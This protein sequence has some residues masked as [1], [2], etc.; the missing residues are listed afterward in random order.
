MTRG[1]IL[2]VEDNADDL[3]LMKRALAKAGIVNPIVTA[4]DGVEALEWLHGTGAHDGRDARDTPVLVLLDLKLPRV[5][6]LEALARLRADERTALVPVVMLTSSREERDLVAS[7]R[8][9]VNGFVRKP[10][11]FEE[12]AE[13]VRTIGLFWLLVNEPPPR[14]GG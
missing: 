2:I 14:S 10:I 4:G 1:R 8:G 12:F 5:D 9:G 7:Y 3:L 6:G 11:D 13:A